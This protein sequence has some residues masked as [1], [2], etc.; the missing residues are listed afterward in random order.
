MSAPGDGRVLNS[1]R[2]VLVAGCGSI[3][4]RHIRNLQSLGIGSL[5]V[6]DTIISR[7]EEVA[8]ELGVELVRTLD[9]AWGRNPTAA[10]IATPTALH[11]ETAIEA[12]EH[13]CHLFIEKPLGAS[14]EGV[15]KFLALVCQNRLITLVGCNM[16]FHPGVSTVKRLVEERIVGKLIS[17]WAEAAQYL[18]DWH[19]AQDY[20]KGYSAQRRLGGGI[21]LDAIHEIDYIRWIMGEITAVSC[22]AG[23]LSS[24]ELDT[25]DTAALL[26]RFT[27]GT[28]GELHLDYVQRAYSRSCKIV[29]ETGTIRWDYTKA[30]VDYY[31]ASRGKWQSIPL[32]ADWQPNDM[33][34]AEM[35]H[36]LNCLDGTEEPQLDAFEAARVLRIALA[37]RESAETGRI[38]RFDGGAE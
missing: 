33:Y 32:P 14:L 28:I 29:G 20:R 3:G 6:Y 31:T 18:P 37:A 12:A 5:L 35:Q 21:I 15:D 23:K 11:L 17:A 8:N 9:A 13:R 7:G 34:L 26:L 25:E 1:D 36:W 30:G 4:T 19:P 27:D 2:T 10:V 24:L 16:R 22:F 38:V